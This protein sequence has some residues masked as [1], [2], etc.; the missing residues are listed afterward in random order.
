MKYKYS[1]YRPSG[2]D[3]ALISQLVHDTELKKKINDVIQKKHSNVEQVG[4][5]GKIEDE[6]FLEMAGGEFCGNAT[7][8]TIHY[9]LNGKP[10][11]M[12]INASGTNKKL[13]GGINP[14]GKVWVEMPINND[15]SKV[16]T[17]DGYRVVEMD[18]ITHVVTPK[19][20]LDEPP[21]ALKEKALSILNA[22]NLTK[23]APAS[24]VMFTT[25]TE[26]GY[27]IDPVVWVQ[28]LETLYY[29]TACGS[30]T[31]AVGLNESINQNSSLSLDITQPSG[32]DIT[33]TIDK[34]NT[35]FIGATITGTVQL[36]D[37]DLE[38]EV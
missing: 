22:L 2:N 4:F 36:L 24:G 6:Y 35:E 26:N 29:E 9:F 10:G 11:S 20:S 5:V 25:K 37:K 23:T 3:T 38:I 18:G 15:L 28:S 31:T 21:N 30:G 16:S 14:D 19:E 8:S 12:V 34:N 1:I 7:R 17:I 32:M 13:K 33:I 27:K